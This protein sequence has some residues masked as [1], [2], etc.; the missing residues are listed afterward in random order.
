MKRTVPLMSIG[1]AVLLT[2]L[3]Y[4]PGAAAGPM[5]RATSVRI[6]APKQRVSPPRSVSGLRGIRSNSGR[7]QGLRTSRDF[8]GS[9]RNRQGLRFPGGSS[10]RRGLNGSLFNGKSG[11]YPIAQQLFRNWNRRYNDHDPYDEI[12]DAYRDAAIANAVVNMVGIIANAAMQ[13]RAVAQPAMM[14]TQTPVSVAQPAPPRGPTGHIE[15]RE[16][17]VREGH[18]Q[19][20]QVHVPQ[21]TIESTGEIV[22]AHYETRRRWVPPVTEVR[23]VWI[24]AP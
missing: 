23:E 21:Y 1:L 15:R 13:P 7:P 8:S 5:R 24:P 22:E 6:N 19:E 12:A 17:V 9:S 11:R 3:A 4:A 14:S 18:Y 10:N 16:V 20:Y 2:A